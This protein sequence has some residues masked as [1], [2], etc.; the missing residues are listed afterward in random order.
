MTEPMTEAVTEAVTEA[1]TTTAPFVSG[2][3]PVARWKTLSE[4]SNVVNGYRSLEELFRDLSGRLRELLNFT[5]LS[6]VLYDASIDG[7]R[8][9]Q[10]QG[11]PM[12]PWPE[13]PGIPISKSPSGKVW[14]TQ[15]ALII[16]DTIGHGEFP[17]VE[18]I[19]ARV[20]VRS[21]LCLPL[22]TV[23]R[24][25]GALNFGNERPHVFDG[26]DLELPLVVASHIAVAVDNA[27]H[28]DAAREFEADL[29]ERHRELLSERQ[30]LDEIVREMPG[31][32]WE[33]HGAPRV[34]QAALL[35]LNNATEA[36]LGYEARELATNPRR[37]L[38]VVDRDDRA[39]LIQHLDRRMLGGP[40][41]T[42]VIRCRKRDATRCWIELHTTPINDSS[43]RTIGLRGVAMDVTQRVAMEGERRRHLAQLAVERTQE[44]ARIAADLHDTLLQSVVGS[45][46]RLQAVA[47]RIPRSA[48]ALRV[49]LADILNLLDHAIADA[50]KA[51]Q[52]L[53]AEAPESD[54]VELLR[55]TAA[56]LDR[57]QPVRF[58]LAVNGAA[59]AIHPSQ[60]ATVHR[61]AG[62]ALTNAYR[63]ARATSIDVHVD[64]RP[65]EVRV[66]I[67]DN[68]IGIDPTVALHGKPGH[69]GVLAMYER[70]EL[71]GGS[72]HIGNGK[73][74]T[75]VELVV[76][77]V[78]PNAT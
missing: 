38:R 40:K 52:G 73:R 18:A 32:V 61:I 19:L 5:Y 3:D 72:L 28:A 59:R 34:A 49:E 76:P 64:F 12:P 45:A 62:E 67:R 43:G 47:S 74:G 14:S 57:E 36:I 35:L 51:V 60:A 65:D 8:V 77:G 68:G 9:W 53:R 46:L 42:L 55:R 16:P 66:L 39:A 15:R 58:R 75:V 13:R 41:E 26:L 50:R 20:N 63:H 69:M 27:L 30:R 56:T 24:R 7:M 17:E 10:I 31:I 33:L 22:T 6:V 2:T 54:L 71:L 37:V 11:A 44:R 70:A 21:F 48:S 1:A 25:L 23:H 29:R 78:L 4:L